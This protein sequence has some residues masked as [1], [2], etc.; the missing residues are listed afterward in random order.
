MVWITYAIE[1]KSKSVVDFILGSKVV[2]MGGE[3]YYIIDCHNNPVYFI[4]T[5]FKQ[6]NPVFKDYNLKNQIWSSDSSIFYGYVVQDQNKKSQ[7]P[8]V[9]ARRRRLLDVA[10]TGVRSRILFGTCRSRSMN[11]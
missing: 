11:C 6:N 5:T 9:C 1:G 8:E 3:S 4:N 7:V 10:G 2:Y